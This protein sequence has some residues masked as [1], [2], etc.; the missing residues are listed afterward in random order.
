MK[1]Y[2]K[3]KL[4]SRNDD[5]MVRDVYGNKVYTVEG[6]GISV[7]RTLRF[8]N[9]NHEEIAMIRQKTDGETPVFCIMRDGKEISQIS[10][11]SEPATR[12]YEASQLDLTIHGSQMGHFFIVSRNGKEVA[13]VRKRWATVNTCYIVSVSE[14]VDP[15]NILAMTLIIDACPEEERNSIACMMSLL[16]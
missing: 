4:F 14:N 7:G 13:T 11:S 15:V 10:G 1:F 3:Q 16:C 5:Y 12:K 2:M 6:E 9:G 8:F